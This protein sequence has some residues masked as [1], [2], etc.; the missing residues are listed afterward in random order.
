MIKICCFL[1]AKNIHT[2]ILLHNID[3]FFDSDYSDSTGPDLKLKG[4]AKKI[5]V[6]RVTDSSKIFIYLLI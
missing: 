5:F 4:R 6:L 2:D 3:W 1:L